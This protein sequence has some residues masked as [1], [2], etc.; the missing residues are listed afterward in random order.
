MV[1][2]ESGYG[3]RL[4]LVVVGNFFIEVYVVV[5][6]E[7]FCR[8]LFVDSLSLGHEE[9]ARTNSSGEDIWRAVPLI[10]FGESI[11]SA[12]HGADHHGRS[13]AYNQGMSRS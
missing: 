11:W 8:I 7:F 9:K 10:C 13:S 6:H 3:F 1:V 4:D 12:T 5:S 2:N